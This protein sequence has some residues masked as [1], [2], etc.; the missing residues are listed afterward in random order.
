MKKPSSLS[1]ALEA[2]PGR[3]EI[4]VDRKVLKGRKAPKE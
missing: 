2:L 4:L 3:K 1:K